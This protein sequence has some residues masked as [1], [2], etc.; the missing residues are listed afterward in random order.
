MSA[1]TKSKDASKKKKR[2]KRP[3]VDLTYVTCAS[4]AV[5]LRRLIKKHNILE[6]EDVG[7]IPRKDI[8]DFLL[9]HIKA[10]GWA[11]QFEMEKK[12]YV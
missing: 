6:V 7:G 1:A 3:L 4:L 8:D 5:D 9:K 10:V 12:E 2:E 11:D